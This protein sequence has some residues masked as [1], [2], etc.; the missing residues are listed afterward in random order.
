MTTVAVVGSEIPAAESQAYVHRLLCSE[1]RLFASR[2]PSPVASLVTSLMQ[3]DPVELKDASDEETDLQNQPMR[4]EQ[5]GPANK[6]IHLEMFIPR[7]ENDEADDV[8]LKK[9][10]EESV[11]KEIEKEKVEKTE[12]EKQIESEESDDVL[13]Y[14]K[15]DWLVHELIT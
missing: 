14:Q 13:D 12:T 11:E 8:T 3:S 1:S 4:E 5:S 2:P 7:V 15:T 10:P 9:E 6:K